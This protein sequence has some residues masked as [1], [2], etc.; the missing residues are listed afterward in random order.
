M[1]TQRYQPQ[2]RTSHRGEWRSS[3]RN[4]K[5]TQSSYTLRGGTKTVSNIIRT[6]DK[7][8]PTR[9]HLRDLSLNLSRNRNTTTITITMTDHTHI[10]PQVLA[11]LAR[12]RVK[13]KTRAR[14]RVRAR[15]RA[16]SHLL[17]RAPDLYP[18]WDL[19]L[20]M[21]LETV[22]QHLLCRSLILVQDQCRVWRSRL[23]DLV[24][25]GAGTIYRR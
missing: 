7:F 6:R 4:W 25:A 12:T 22:L 18:P 17:Y 24:S 1:R 9:N 10:Y 21:G 11:L 3:R 2:V 23:L 14:A 15:V 5:S 16:R 20:D 19:D 13:A 8:K